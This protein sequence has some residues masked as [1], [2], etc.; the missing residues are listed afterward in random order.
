MKTSIR[1]IMWLAAAILPFNELAH[2][3]QGTAAAQPVEAFYCDMREGKGMK[4]LLAVADRFRKWADKHDDGYSAWILTPMFGQFGE[5]PQVIWLGS[6]QS[7]DHMGKGLDAWLETGT[8]IQDAFDDVVTCNAHALASSTEV[9]APDGPPA[10]G[11]VM[12]TQCTLEEAGGLAGAVAAH[13]KA[14]RAMRDL[15]AANSS[16]IFVPMLGG[17]DP[18]FDYWSVAT[19]EDW[20]SYFKAYELYVNGGG[21][22]KMMQSLEGVANCSDVTPTVWNVKLVRRAQD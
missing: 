22:Q 10:D 12:F 1:T 11:V 9:L 4:D 2:A 14:A 8:D 3:Q 17:G 7:G 16:W 18:D 19:F 15:G 21:G 5:L 20:S 13:T 6:N